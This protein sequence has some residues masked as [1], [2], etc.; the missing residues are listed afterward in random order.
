MLETSLFNYFLD[1]SDGKCHCHYNLQVTLKPLKQRCRFDPNLNCRIKLV[2]VLCLNFQLLFNKSQK[3]K[4]VSCNSFHAM[5]GW[6]SAKDW[7]ARIWQKGNIEALLASG[8]DGLCRR[9]RCPFGEDSWER[10]V[11]QYF[12]I[13]FSPKLPSLQIK[14]KLNL[15]IT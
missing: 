6:V 7:D 2:S 11:K 14:G 1:P 4:K 3:K 12:F 13:N 15:S 9:Q 5:M 8:Q 10:E